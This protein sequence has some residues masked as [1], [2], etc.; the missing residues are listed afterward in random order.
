MTWFQAWDSVRVLRPRVQYGGAA[1]VNP[2]GDPMPTMVQ[3]QSF[4][5]LQL[6]D[7]DDATASMFE[8]WYSPD[9]GATWAPIDTNITSRDYAW[10]VPEEATDQALL[11]VV[12]WDELGI[13]GSRV[14][15][16]FQIIHQTTGVADGRAPERFSLR[17]SGHNPASRALLEFGMPV[18]GDVSVR[19]YDVQGALVRELARGPY[20]PGW[21][22]VAW[23]GAGATGSP[24]EPGVYFV[25]SVANG[26]RL[27]KRFVLLK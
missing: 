15:N 16:V 13:M 1:I 19:V 2:N 21:H 17:F 11:G 24:A 27:L 6:V 7:P 3:S 14:T 23:D 20:E 12:A 22:R 5:P 9:A 25:Q 10:S 18:R 8:L 26:Q 4:V